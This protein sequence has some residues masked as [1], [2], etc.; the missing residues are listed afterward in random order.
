MVNFIF[1]FCFI[2]ITSFVS[3]ITVKRIKKMKI[4]ICDNIEL[5]RKKVY[6]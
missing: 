1:I 6:N 2:S 3:V 5:C 4:E